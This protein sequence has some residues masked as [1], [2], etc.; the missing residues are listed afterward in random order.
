[1]QGILCFLVEN[2][3]IS[4]DLIAEIHK[5]KCKAKGKDHPVTGHG[6]R[7]RGDRIISLLFI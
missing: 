4:G 3:H 5:N 2:R 1:M 7:E 6:D